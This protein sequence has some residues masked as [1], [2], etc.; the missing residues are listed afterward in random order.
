LTVGEPDDHQYRQGIRALPEDLR[1]GVAGHDTDAQPSLALVLA[2]LALSVRVQ[3]VVL[4][5]IAQSARR[6]SPL[7]G[8][9]VRYFNQVLTSADIS[10]EASIGPGL[11]LYHPAGVVIGPDCHV[12]R[13]CTIMQGV[14][15]GG[16]PNGRGGSP[17]LGDHVYVGPGAQVIGGIEIGSHAS[18]GANAV[19]L[20]DVPPYAFA[21]GVPAV[22]RRINPE[23]QPASP[24]ATTDT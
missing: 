9:I 12:G 4:M 24:A 11:V 21:A 17:R 8:A 14:T 22:V 20:A 16:G 15:L 7:L 23:G 6:R 1:L 10:L 5:R 13:R 2:K 19:V 3:A 18:I